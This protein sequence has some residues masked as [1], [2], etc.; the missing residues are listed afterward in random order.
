M[1]ITENQLRRIIRKNLDSLLI[2][3]YLPLI[4]KNISIYKHIFNQVREIISYIE[5]N[6]KIIQIL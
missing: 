2:E 6:S 3:N 5:L 1:K 4:T